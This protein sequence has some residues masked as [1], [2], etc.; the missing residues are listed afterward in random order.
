M[1]VS[2][3]IFSKNILNISRA[4]YMRGA[5]ETKR[6]SHDFSP[7]RG[8]MFQKVGGGAGMGNGTHLGKLWNW[9]GTFP[10]CWGTK[11]AGN[12]AEQVGRGHY[13]PGIGQPQVQLEAR[14]KIERTLQ[15]P[16]RGREKRHGNYLWGR[17]GKSGKWFDLSLQRESKPG[18]LLGLW[19]R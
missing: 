16:E 13:P 18:W 9:P 1:D 6:K 8:K 2:L 3:L 17:T 7:Q 19:L 4:P 10:F 15:N 12:A 5:E 11:G 14:R